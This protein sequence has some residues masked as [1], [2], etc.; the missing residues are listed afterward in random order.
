MNDFVLQQI[1]ELMLHFWKIGKC[2]EAE[3]VAFARDNNLPFYCE[4]T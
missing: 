2:K 4:A 3:L 1:N